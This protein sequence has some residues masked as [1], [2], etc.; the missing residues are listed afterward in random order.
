MHPTEIDSRVERAINAIRANWF[1]LVQPTLS[2]RQ[3]LSTRNL[4]FKGPLWISRTTLPVI[5]DEE[6]RRIFLQAITELGDRAVT[7]ALSDT[8]TIEVEW[9]GYRRSKPQEESRMSERELYD[10]LLRDV[11]SEVTIIYV[12]GG[13]YMSDRSLPLLS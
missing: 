9:N 11:S 8:E 5:G 12:H 2:E 7:F 6:L 13:G 4:P 1:P 3:A 10:C